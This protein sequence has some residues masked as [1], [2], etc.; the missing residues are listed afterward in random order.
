MNALFRSLRRL[1]TRLYLGL[2]AAVLLTV[3]AS[4]VGWFSFH[5]VGLLQDVVNNESIPDMGAAVRAAQQSGSLV[6]QA[7]LLTAA[8]VDNL[9]QIKADIARERD[10][11]EQQLSAI[12][13]SS[14]IG[15]EDYFAAIQANAQTLI[16]NIGIIEQEVDDR[17][18][19]LERADVVK[20][21]LASLQVGLESALVE[22]LDDQ[23]FFL[24]TGYRALNAPPASRDLHLNETQITRYRHL[25]NLQSNASLAIQDL[26]N[27]FAVTEAA[28][29]EP[30][31]ER[32]EATRRRIDRSLQ[33][34]GQSDPISLQVSPMFD[35]LFEL[36]LGE[37]TG[38]ALVAEI[39][40]SDSRQA[41]L[42]ETN[43][44]LGVALLSAVENLVQDKGSQARTASAMSTLAI[45]TGR[46]LLLVLI[47][48]SIVGAL[49]IAWLF[50]GRLLLRRLATLSRR[51]QRMADG[52]LEGRVEI[53]GAD[54]IADMAAALE[55][56][57][58]HALE[59]QRLNLVEKLAEELQGKNDQLEQ[60]LAELE[61]AQD[62]VIT[63]EKLAALG[64]LTAGVAH[65]IRNPLNFVKNF[66]EV[67]EELLDEMQEELQDLLGDA[68]IAEEDDR[69][70][71]L[72][73]L[74]GDLSDNLQRIRQHADR[75]NGIVESM[76][77][78][79]RDTGEWVKTNINSI[80]DEH[81]RLAFHSARA[82]DPDFQLHMEMDLYPDLPEVEIVP[83][84]LGRVF[85]N[86]VSNA[87][88]ATNLRREELQ[89]TDAAYMPTLKVT[90][91]LD[92]DHV[93]IRMY[94]NGTGMPAEVREK[95]FN[96]FFTT[97]PTNEGTGL[98]LALSS[99]IVR[100]H[101]GTIAV[102]S[103][104]NEFTEM[105]VRL[106]L[107]QPAGTVAG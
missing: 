5:R 51:M 22:A 23:L 42:L 44:E 46:T 20:A 49:L 74:N 79:G 4:L 96:P 16:A 38:F 80:V 97:K 24:L 104:P 69:P 9:P 65:E 28:R 12:R 90:T 82:K 40:G 53:G 76:L 87:C 57:R 39:I 55:V 25:T 85:L 77:R 93:E 88:Y 78:M 19:L 83:Q 86:M 106:P 103:A 105:T 26:A 56:F 66:S 84:N 11:F 54:E 70:G 71:Y 63:Q 64:E 6:A 72:E 29:L 10:A 37:D 30:L 60:V 58:R 73:E 43:Q 3:V 98:G 100:G 31:R 52:D 41:A 1:G 13:A 36:A 89:S 35:R 62:Q 61:K 92:G 27:A 14:D 17:F 102:E 67:S 7:P 95:I 68:E 94:D 8:T 101:G 59:V 48:V 99:D 34:L 15:E 21:D 18:L 32:S 2:G 91:R 75:A 107:V 81:T 47:V 50:V 45:T 33:A